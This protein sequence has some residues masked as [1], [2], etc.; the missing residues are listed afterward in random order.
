MRT[1][2]IEVLLVLA[3]VLVV[4]VPILRVIYGQSIRQWERESFERIGISPELGWLLCGVIGLTLVVLRF[5]RRN[6][7]DR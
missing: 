4:A 7:Q 5:R 1:R 2:L 6:R 3:I